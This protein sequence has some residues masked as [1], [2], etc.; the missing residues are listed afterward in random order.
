MGGV[1]GTIQNNAAQLLSFFSLFNLYVYFLAI[2]YAPTKDA[3]GPAHVRLTN[4]AQMASSDSD[5]DDL[6][7]A[8]VSSRRRGGFRDSYTDEEED[9]RGSAVSDLGR[10]SDE[11]ESHA[12]KPAAPSYSSDGGDDGAGGGAAAAAPPVFGAQ[13]LQISVQPKEPQPDL[14]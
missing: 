3:G 10:D 6:G 11:A 1:L 2:V 4:M 5:S 8:G 13:P 9:S 12:M 14:L 7:A